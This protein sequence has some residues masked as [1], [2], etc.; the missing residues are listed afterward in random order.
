VL[1]FAAENVAAEQII[2]IVITIAFIV[3]PI[4]RN[5]NL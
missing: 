2:N 5:K 1:F 4:L 3:A